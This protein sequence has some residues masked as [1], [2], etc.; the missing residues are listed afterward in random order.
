MAKLIDG[1][2]G[3]RVSIKHLEDGGYDFRL[4]GEE[5]RAHSFDY[6]VDADSLPVATIGCYGI[7]DIDTMAYVKFGFTPETIGEAMAVVRSAL[8]ND[9]TYYD[10]LVAS[11]RSVFNEVEEEEV[12]DHDT[13]AKRV[14]NRI[15]GRTI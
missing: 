10:G 14:A 3:R 15:I 6:H 7:P 8:I 2:T 11:I 4:D 5:F 9:S 12:I 1:I 13:L